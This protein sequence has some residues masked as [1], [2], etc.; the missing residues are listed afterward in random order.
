MNLT[1]KLATTN[2]FEMDADMRKHGSKSR[3]T[4]ALND[5]IKLI[6]Q[7][8]RFDNDDIFETELGFV[9]RSSSTITSVWADKE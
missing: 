7:D 4:D 5:M 3:I 8:D 9:L 1:I 6:N 2:G